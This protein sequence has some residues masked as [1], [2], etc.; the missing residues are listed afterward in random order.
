LRGDRCRP[1]QMVP[2]ITVKCTI[3]KAVVAGVDSGRLVE[4]FYGKR[5]L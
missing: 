2:K 3:D 4:T 1:L 5:L